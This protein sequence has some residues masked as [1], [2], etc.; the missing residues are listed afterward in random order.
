MTGHRAGTFRAYLQAS[1]SCEA[2]SRLFVQ[3]SQL[4]IL[5]LVMTELSPEVVLLDYYLKLSARNFILALAMKFH[6]TAIHYFVIEFRHN[7]KN[8][9]I[10]C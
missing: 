3:D 1:Y 6:V 9:Q 8:G 10:L 2:D 5:F 4:N 7:G